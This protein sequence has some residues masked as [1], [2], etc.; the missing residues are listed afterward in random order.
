[1]TAFQK[2]ENV[3]A[4]LRAVLRKDTNLIT[5]PF[6]QAQNR[7]PEG[8][9]PP[10]CCADLALAVEAVILKMETDFHLDAAGRI[11][12]SAEKNASNN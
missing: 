1:M 7:Q 11:A 12:D 8:E 10:L 4:Q 3:E 6:C 9:A 2:L 5:C